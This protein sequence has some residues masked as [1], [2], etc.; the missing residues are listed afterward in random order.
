MGRVSSELAEFALRIGTTTLIDLSKK[1]SF[2]STKTCTYARSLAWEF[3]KLDEAIIVSGYH[4]FAAV[5]YIN[6]IDI[7]L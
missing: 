2:K 1:S 4:M 5:A 7:S 3:E 6:A